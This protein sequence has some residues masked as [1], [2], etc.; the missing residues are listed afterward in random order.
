[1]QQNAIMSETAITLPHSA[2]IDPAAD[3]IQKQLS[4]FLEQTET[5]AYLMARHV[6]RD[7]DAA[8]ELVQEAMTRLVS[9]YRHRPD[10]IKAQATG[11]VTLVQI[12]AALVCLDGHCT[13]A[14]IDQ[15]LP[16]AR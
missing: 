5:R 9:H 2:L 12:P 16:A 15:R 4:R 11:A 13:D 1:M 8:L 14:A 6:T 3:T 7:S 10:R